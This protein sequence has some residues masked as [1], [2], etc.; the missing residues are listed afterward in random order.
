MGGAVSGAKGFPEARVK[1]PYT[2][3]KAVNHLLKARCVALVRATFLLAYKSAGRQIDYQS[4][5]LGASGLDGGFP[6]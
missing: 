3:F 6:V 4:S 2:T 1:K 5:A